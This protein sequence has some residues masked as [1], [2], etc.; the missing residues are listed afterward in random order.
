[1]GKRQALRGVSSRPEGLNSEAGAHGGRTPASATGIVTSYP[2]WASRKQKDRGFAPV[3]G[4]PRAAMGT[5]E[6]G[7][8]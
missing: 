7:A 1:M 2:D 4:H 8:C 3:R 6:A 5:K